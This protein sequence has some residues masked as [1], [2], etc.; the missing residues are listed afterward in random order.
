M[1][2]ALLNLWVLPR[3]VAIAFVLLWRKLISP[4]YGDVCRYYPSCSA[5]GLGSLQQHGIVYGSALTVW[6]IL[7]CN[8]F[9]KG[10]VDEVSPGPKW[11]ST[12]DSGL[13]YVRSFSKAKREG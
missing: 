7:R 13:V 5:Y 9:S 6:R 10:G 8:P 11:I 3:N 2:T 4:L 1:I 12:A